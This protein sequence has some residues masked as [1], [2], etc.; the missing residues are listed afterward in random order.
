MSW[1]ARASAAF[2][3]ATCLVACAGYVY[4][5]GRYPRYVDFDSATLGIFVNDLSYHQFGYSFTS[6]V[7]DVERPEQEWYRLRW[8]AS[9][10]PLTLPL[11]WLQR[12]FRIPPEHAGLLIRGAASFFGLACA[13]VA[14]WG[15]SSAGGWGASDAA[16]VVALCS[17]F[18]PFLL[19]A[20]TGFPNHLLA[21]FLFWSAIALAL[22]F[23]RTGRA[24]FLIFLGIVA[25][26]A[27]LNPYPPM[28]ALPLLVLVL[29]ARRPGFLALV[30]NPACYVAIG[31][32]AVL[33]LG[34]V[35]TFARFVG[36]PLKV[37][38]EFLAT[39]RGMRGGLSLVDISVKDVPR[40]LAGLL[41][42]Q[43][44]F[45]R[46]TE[47]RSGR[48]DD[49]WALG[50]PD[51]AWFVVVALC[52]IGAVLAVRRRTPSGII[53]LVV[54]AGTI[55]VLT[56]HGFP[57]VRYVAI[58]AP[59]Y[60]VL[61]VCALRA[62]GLPAV[63]RNL[64]SGTL[65][66]AASLNTFGLIVRDYAPRQ[67]Q[68]WPQVDGIEEFARH[69][70]NWT[71]PLRFV[72]FP[73]PK[74]YDANLYLRMLTNSNA[75]WLTEQEFKRE[76]ESAERQARPADRFYLV[77]PAGDAAAIA[78]WAERGFGV[79]SRFDARSGAGPLVLL[80]RPAG[81]SAATALER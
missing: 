71:G 13:I 11:S 54:L 26:C 70:G 79:L 64:V 76:L 43:V 6:S 18:P 65:V 58:V 28:L 4:E 81:R 69:V 22:A 30:K 55:A 51:A 16:V 47:I 7:R 27:L 45:R 48:S 12:A 37:Y 62:F 29:F 61:A 34:I 66:L 1:K 20:R 14:A 67:D 38:R 50:S 24:A 23:R 53:A 63:L 49:L 19:N 39:F 80:G 40:R 17:V 33:Y 35:A 77:A 21:Y 15:I 2:L 59:C 10:L 44:L 68:T 60:G 3:A 56:I 57:E 31:A 73:F 41:D 78:G 75:R 8:A 36:M 46:S 9:A 52:V 25:A 5:I 42:N 32:A 72:T 74:I